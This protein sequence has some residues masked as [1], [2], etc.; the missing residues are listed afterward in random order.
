MLAAVKDGVA[1]SD[2]TTFVVAR[3]GIRSPIGCACSS[4]H[5]YEPVSVEEQVPE[6]EECRTE[7]AP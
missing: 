7:R 6:A 1:A 5:N 3:L 2:D 4:V